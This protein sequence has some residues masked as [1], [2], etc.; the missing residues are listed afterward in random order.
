MD[1]VKE[2]TLEFCK[3]QTFKGEILESVGLLEEGKFDVIKS[4]IDS[5]MKAGQ[6]TDIGHEYKENIIE[7]YESTVRNVIPTGWDVLM[8]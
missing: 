7:R 2:Q 5:A 4:L 3:N 8:N 1:Y 6:D